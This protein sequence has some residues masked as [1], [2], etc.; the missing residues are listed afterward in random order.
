MG[1]KK[2]AFFVE[3]Y[4]EQ[5]FLEKLLLE[6][7]S[8][9]QI[10]IEI[11]KMKGGKKIPISFSSIKSTLITEDTKYFVLIYNCGGDSNVK[12]YILER[13]LDLAKAGYCKI[14]GLRDIF[15][16][17][18]RKDIHELTYFLNYKVP[19]KEIKIEFVISIMEIESWFMS[20]HTHFIK[21]N[22]CF[23]SKNVKSLLGFDL[24]N[25]NTEL[26]DAPADTLN[27]IYGLCG[28]TYEKTKESIDRTVEAID[29]SEIY[30]ESRKRI[31][32]LDDLILSFE[33]IFN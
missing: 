15:P 24:K 28:E 25:Y 9:R 29:Y 19:Q 32:S 20:D 16:D 12:S 8:E 26:I 30:F 27:K 31:K 33:E 10:S 21:V 14:V 5:Y 18:E 11:Q 13:R 17:F 3:G 2:I 6:I 1:F 4:T 22:P 7:F 23:D